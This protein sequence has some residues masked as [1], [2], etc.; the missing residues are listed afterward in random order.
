MI[1]ISDFLYE[2]FASYWYFNERVFGYNY[3]RCS[4]FSN[5]V[6]LIFMHFGTA[7]MGA[8]LAY[9]PET[10]STSFNHLEYDRPGCYNACCCC[11]KFCC[12]YLSKYCYIET[13]LQ[14]YAFWPANQQMFYLKRRVKQQ[15]PQLYMMGNFYETAAKTFIVLLSMVVC[16]LFLITNQPEYY[17]NVFNLIT[18]LVVRTFAKLGDSLHLVRNR[19]PFHELHRL[20]RRY[21]RDHVLRGP[22]NREVGVRA[23]RSLQLSC[24][25]QANHSIVEIGSSVIL[26]I[27]FRQSKVLDRIHH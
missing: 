6:K 13:I 5:S 21:A 16:Y 8:I 7:C 22:R 27:I 18:P 12:R 2:G 10:L 26:V 4:N 19:H 23:D 9:L 14:S 17:H 11:H 25:A 24:G 3:S 20:D 15:V 1:A